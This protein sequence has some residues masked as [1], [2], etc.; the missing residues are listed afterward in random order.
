M[1]EKLRIV[2]KK[3]TCEATGQQIEIIEIHKDIT[4]GENLLTSSLTEVSCLNFRQCNHPCSL[5]KNYNLPVKCNKP[6]LIRNNYN[7]KQ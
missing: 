1:A 3:K 5:F 7:I 2:T 4:D 6:K